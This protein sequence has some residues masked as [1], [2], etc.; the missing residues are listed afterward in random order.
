MSPL[1]ESKTI[2]DQLDHIVADLERLTQRVRDVELERDR[3]R[4]EVA[5]LRADRNQHLEA[6][7]AYA[8]AEVA[9][10]KLAKTAKAEPTSVE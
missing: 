8:R 7:S 2:S 9:L 1:S 6:L 5:D 3:L 10:E 4:E